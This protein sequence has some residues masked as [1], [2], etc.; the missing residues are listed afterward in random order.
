MSS[1]DALPVKILWTGGWDSTFQLLRLLLEERRPVEPVYLI[2]EKRRSL[3]HELMAM[4]MIRQTLNEKYPHTRELL[5][6]PLFYSLRDIPIPESVTE[7][8]KQ[9]KTKHGIGGQYEWLASFCLHYGVHGLQLC[10]HRDD[11]AYPPAKWLTEGEADPATIQSTPEWKIFSHFQY[12][13]LELTKPDMHRI[14]QDHGWNDLMEMTWFCHR[15]VHDLPCGQCNPCQYTIV[16]G[17]AHRIPAHRRIRTGFGALD[18]NLLRLASF[19]YRL[20]N[21]NPARKKGASQIK[22]AP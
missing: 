8:F 13:I 10:I 2:D 15:P 22:P 6:I 7:A 5:Q 18:R 3:R 17:M 19:S 9:L 16:E 1:P 12:P 20:T 11:K 4:R 14:A 21:R